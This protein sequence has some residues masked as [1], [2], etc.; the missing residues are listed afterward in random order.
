M[1]IT[2]HLL[3]AVLLLAVAACEQQAPQVAPAPVGMVLIP[4]GEFVMGSDAVDSDGKQ[5]EFGFRQPMYLDEH[6]RHR[7]KLNAFYID[8]FEV[9]NGDY[10]HF[11]QETHIS[12]PSTWVQNGY[13]VSDRHLASF[14][15]NNLRKV[16]RD[17]FQLDMDT[18][19]MD[20]KALLA[21]LRRIQAERNKL[22]VTV[23]NWYDA[24]SFCRWQG[25]RLPS[26]AE[27]EKAARG[28]DGRRYPWGNEW[29]QTRTNVGDNNDNDAIVAASGSYPDD[30]SPYGV[31]DL[32][33]NVSEWV[34]DWYRP[35]PGAD[36]QSKFFG[37]IQKVVKG[38]GAGVGHYALS[39]FFR[40]ARRGHADPSTLAT[41]VGFRCAESAELKS[42]DK[43]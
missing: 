31:F 24:A 5:A 41:D 39:Y 22:P 2:R 20:R 7:V 10:K 34:N 21:E 15:L 27:W 9:S 11:V 14:D 13:N 32:A 18:T 38:G 1:A 6:P 29:D 30:R 35:Y 17:Y 23:V 26:E 4:A 28:P 33:G 43:R 19:K 40:A 42:K 25:K 12:E 16:A 37:D 36:F 8:K 3:V